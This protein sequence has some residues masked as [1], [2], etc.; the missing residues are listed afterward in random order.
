MKEFEHLYGNYLIRPANSV[1][2]DPYRHYL[3][4]SNWFDNVIT[5]KTPVDVQDKFLELYPQWIQSSKLNTVK[6]LETLPNRHV[7]LGTTQAMDDFIMY[8][9]KT[10]RRLRVLKGEY[11]Y[12]REVS[13]CDNI[14]QTVDDF[15]LQRND[16]L[17]ISAPFSATGDIHPRWE[18]LIN[19]CN[20][21]DIPVFVDCAFYG[22][23]L[24]ITLD[25][26]HPCI[27]TVSFSPTKGLNCGNMRTGMIFTKRKGR[28][29]ALEILSEWH[30]GIHIHTYIA[31]MLMQNFSPD[32]IPN[33]YR[34]IQ[35]KAC[36]HYQLT[37]TNT[38]HLGLGDSRWEYFSRENVSNRVCL[39]NA[40]YDYYH[41]GTFK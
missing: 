12:G 17:L 6:G 13:D 37:P 18:E 14:C 16:A 34:D 27:D 36:E 3:K 24:N 7:S 33:T 9:L 40:I 11:G 23:C 1:M 20:K 4:D 32:T 28:D 38:I 2:H 5:N 31:Y 25:F 35:L 29:C 41:N 39:R 21:L 30:H 26:N 15:P 19:T 10:K 8:T 22:T